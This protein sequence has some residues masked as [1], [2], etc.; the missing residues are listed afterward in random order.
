MSEVLFQPVRGSEAGIAKLEKRN[1]RVYFATDSGKIYVDTDQERIAMGAAGAA[2]YYGEA[3]SPEQDPDTEYYIFH[4]ADLENYE[5][6]DPKPGDLILNSEDGG[7]YRV[8]SAQDTYFEC[9]LLSISGVGGGGG[10]GSSLRPLLSIKSTDSTVINGQ[11]AKVTFEVESAKDVDGSLIDTSLTVVWTLKIK[12]STVGEESYFTNNISVPLDI[13]PYSPTFGKATVTFD[14]GPYLRS[15]TTTY[16]ELFAQGINHDAVSRTLTT[17]ITSSQLTLSHAAGYSATSTHTLNNI[18]VKCNVVGSIPK[19]LDYYFDN[20]LVQTDLL[21]INSQQEQQLK[22]SNIPTKLITHGAHKIRIELYQDLGSGVRGLPAEPLEFE[23]AVVKPGDATQKP[24]IWFGSYKSEYYN[25]DTI[26][27]PFLVYDPAN[28]TLATVRLYK[29]RVEQS[30]REIK[31]FSKMSYWEI[32]DADLDQMNSY[33]ISCGESDDRRVEREIN[34]KVVKDPN[35]DMTIKTENLLLN[36]VPTGR[37]NSE[38]AAQR[39]TWTYELEGET[40]KAVFTNFN[41]CNNG[42]HMDEETKQSCLRISNGARFSIPLFKNGM[43][44]ASSSSGEQ[45]NTI[46]IQF[47]IRNVQNYSNLITNITRYE[48]DDAWYAAFLNQDK[49]TNY[50][51]YLQATL[52]PDV[53]DNLV[54]VRVQKNINLSNIVCGFYSLDENANVTGACIGTQDAFFSNGANTV[55]VSFVENEINNISFVYSHPLKSIYVYINGVITGVIKSTKDSIFKIDSSAIEF[56]STA[57]DIDLYKLRVYNTDL[58]VNNIVTNFAV[59]RKD[60]KTFDQNGLAAQNLS[61]QEYQL[62]FEAVEKYNEL[63]PN[64]PLMP[65]IIFDTTDYKDKKLPWSKQITRNIKVTFINTPLEVAYI[66]GQLEEKARED[67]LIASGETDPAAIK[68]GVKE[69]YKHHCPSWVSTMRASDRVSIDVQGTS[70]EFYPRRNFKVKTKSKG[71]YCWNEE[72][73]KYDESSALNIFMNRG[74]YAEVYNADKANVTSDPKTYLGYEESRLS[75]GWYMNNYTNGTD[76][77]TFKVDYM[78]SS[79]SY[80][81][82][83]ASLV[84]TAYSK[85]PLQDHTSHLTNTD[86]LASVTECADLGTRWEDYRTSLLGF[87]VMAFQKRGENDYLFIGYYRMLLDKGSDEVLGFKPSS[88]VTN[89]FFPK[90]DGTFVPQKEI[91]ECWE[92]ATNNRTFCSFRDPW[93]RVQLSFKAP[94]GDAKEFTSDGAPIVMN[95]FEY[96]YHTAKDHLEKLFLFNSLNEDELKAITDACGWP[97]QISKGDREA[98]QLLTLSFYKNWEKVCGWV[99]STN[100]DAVCSQGIYIPAPVAEAL[101]VSNKYYINDPSAEDG[102]SIATGEFNS[103]IAYYKKVKDKY[104]GIV[105]TTNSEYVYRANTFYQL[106]GGAYSLVSESVY[107]SNL[108][109]YRFEETEDYKSIADLLLKPAKEAGPFDENTQYY[110]YDGTVTINPEASTGAVIPVEDPVESA[111]NAD[112]YYVPTTVTYSG[113]TY[114]H[115]TKE[116]RTA[117]FVNEFTQHFDPEYV[118]TYFIMTEVFECYDSRGKNCMMASWGPKEEGGEYIW[119]PIFYDIDT[120]LGINNTGIPSFEFN[121]DATEAGN[122]STSDSILWNNFYRFFKDSYIVQKYRNLRGFSNNKFDTLDNPPLENVNNLESWYLFDPEVT[123][124]IAAQGERPLIATN[125]DMFFKYI[126]ITNPNAASQGVQYLLGDGT[127]PETPNNGTFF[128]AL[129]GDRSQ[130]RRQFLTNRLEYID[131]WLTQGNYARGGNNHVRGRIAANNR[132]DL[133]SLYGDVTSDKWTEGVNEKG[134]YWKDDVEFGT[135]MHEFDAEYWLSVVP[136]R[137]AYVTAGDDSANYPSQKYDGINPLKFKLNELESGIRRSQNYPEQLLY[138]YGTNQMSDLGDMSKMYWTEFALEGNAS[139]LTR[140][141]LGHDG[142]TYDYPSDQHSEKANI[143]WYNRKLNTIDIPNLPLLKEANFSNLGLIAQTTLDLTQSEKLENLRAAGSS[144]LTMIKFAE[145]VAL[146]T[147]YLPTSIIE[148]SLTQANLLTDLITDPAE[149][150]PVKNENGD[151]VAKRG[152]YLEGFFENNFSSS[153]T[154]LNLVGGALGYNSHTILKKFWE[155]KKVSGS[156]SQ[157]TML[158]VNWCPYTK[159]TEGDVYDPEAIYYVDNGHYGFDLYH[160]DTSDENA[161]IKFNARILNGEIYRDDQTTSEAVVNTVDDSTVEM[162]LDLSTN[163][164]FKDATGLARPNIS[165]IIYIKN[166]SSIEESYI[167][168]TLQAKYPNLTFFFE[169]VQKAYS[170]KFIIYDEKTSSYEYVKHT[171]G[172]TTPSIQKISR[173]DYIK[174]PNIKFENPYAKYKPEKTHYDFKGWSSS[175]LKKDIIE[176]ADWDNQEIDPN[177]YD[178]TYYAIFE[179]HNYVLTFYNHDGAEVI[180][181][182]EVPYGQKA[183]TP[184]L[185]PY[186]S[187]AQLGLYETYDFQGYSLAPDGALFDVVSMTVSSDEEYYAIFKLVEDVRK[188]VHPEWFTIVNNNFTY[189]EHAVLPGSDYYTSGLSICPAVK[190]KGKITIPR[191]I[192]GYPVVSLVDFDTL[193]QEITH[194]FMEHSDEESGRAP[195][196]VI[197]YECFNDVDT[198]KY[199]DFTNSNIRYVESGGFRRCSLD[200]SI[201]RLDLAPLQV[202]GPRGFNQGFTFTEATTLLIPSCLKRV[203]ENGFTNL[204]TY[205]GSTLQIGTQEVFSDLDLGQGINGNNYKQFA[206]N[207]PFKY[208]YFYSNLYDDETDIVKDNYTVAQCLGAVAEGGSYSII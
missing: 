83:F 160:Y 147:L 61:L 111:Y 149:A 166:N 24:I 151:L 143:R 152:L 21:G 175:P 78:E 48:G 169:D 73:Q 27:I 51:A 207:N 185:I 189:D 144:N 72:D 5:S 128:Y 170:A 198:L 171:D 16:V 177:V 38:A 156:G 50:D 163:K 159:L 41:W 186:R 118:A 81:A 129:Q 44:F 101:Y 173:N 134:Q 132:N 70:S 76:R 183:I 155:V 192:N 87:P 60:V 89:K 11:P 99:W 182:E 121:V 43:T 12:N 191:Y 112:L 91:T 187:D 162:L 65:Y 75:D 33:Q 117:K 9:S 178:Y 6:D 84:G 102:Y 115:D 110:F 2:I 47:K 201:N 205:P 22:M 105:L 94:V 7:F 174:D 194:V 52:D 13:N 157:V 15:S 150:I 106:V 124:N 180:A 37:S 204:F 57:C 49:Y 176:E 88:K 146:N 136:I 188:V 141:K 130:S 80:N 165:G 53:Y 3:K 197:Q 190:L 126:T 31:D 145:G 181:T 42:W 54:F 79:G 95:N 114:T 109:Y 35:R 140:L 98:G 71:D 66:N 25:Y 148:L 30:I 120:Q 19:I 20:T 193:E 29:N 196:T 103:D 135:K 34:F 108:Q 92:F 74:P 119:Y 82:G 133:D 137:S 113:K 107:N 26:Q 202:V 36:F 104:E 68:A 93:N 56:N 17:I 172:T 86:K 28:T 203:S 63:N 90:D 116:Y 208:I 131:S 77:W 154:S 64:Q 123:N 32:A 8:V 45:S 179:I 164:N 153:I 62:S 18:I 127:Y 138:I 4:R 168:D 206:Q 59:D 85:H 69:Y 195:L 67:G 40:K 161:D 199:F 100:I 58:N 46:E 125:L 39:Q 167:R 10:I 158:D 55:N 1:G 96:R 122:Y 139:K 184:N 97:T 23:I 142:L 14:F 200:P